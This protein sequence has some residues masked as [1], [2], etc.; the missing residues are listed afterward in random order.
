VK[1]YKVETLES[2]DVEGVYFVEASSSEE[3]WNIVEEGSAEM[4]DHHVIDTEIDLI[5][6]VVEIDANQQETQETVE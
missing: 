1:E 3:A 4:I 6:E 2:W 5:T